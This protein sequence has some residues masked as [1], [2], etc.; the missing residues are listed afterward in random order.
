[1]AAKSLAVKYRP[2]SFEDVT[3]QSAITIILNKQLASGEIKHGYLFVGPAGTGKTT[4]ARI[5]ADEINKGQGN[6]IEMD[7]ASHNSVDDIREINSAAWNRSLD[8]EYKVFIIDECHS[9]SNAAW[10]AMLKT[11]EEPPAKT[12]FIF[13]TTDPQKIPKTILSRVQ[14][15]NF[16]KISKEGIHDRLVEILRMENSEHG[17]FAANK[18]AID[19]IARA[20]EGGMRNAITMLD[21]CLAYSNTLTIEKVMDVLGRS[22][23]KD[24]IELTDYIHTKDREV[25]IN[26]L[27]E[28]YS[29]GVDMKQFIHDYLRT[30]LDFSKVVLTGD[31]NYTRLPAS[32]DVIHFT[33]DI[34]EEWDKNFLPCLIDRLLEIENQI[35]WSEDPLTIVEAQLIYFNY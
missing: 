26:I 11:L 33:D 7:A 22:D 34:R 31:I 35:K 13:C 8:S 21:K 20:A 25:I 6:P 10:Q 32:G 23:I 27:E 17:K 5:F 16:K 4:C 12:I 19:Y 30:V 1:M 3:E 28:L 2:K 24:M 29:G 14:R 18:D 9:L 15:Y